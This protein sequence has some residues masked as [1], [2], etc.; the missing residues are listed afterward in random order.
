MVWY[1]PLG[2]GDLLTLGQ[3]S[4]GCAV[5]TGRR[6]LRKR[7]MIFTTNTPL[8]HWGRVLHDPNLAA[9]ILDSRDLGRAGVN[10]VS[11]ASQQWWL[12]T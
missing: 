9:A 12:S 4:N 2:A 5:R 7:P 6:H 3:T 10:V 8:N 1:L 11:S